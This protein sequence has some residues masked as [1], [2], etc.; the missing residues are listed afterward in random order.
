ML[1][2]WPWIIICPLACSTRCRKAP[3]HRLVRC[4]QFHPTE[5]PLTGGWLLGGGALSKLHQVPG[6][7]RIEDR[8]SFFLV[9]FSK[10]L[11]GGRVERL[12]KYLLLFKLACLTLIVMATQRKDGFLQRTLFRRMGR[13]VGNYVLSARAS[14][15]G[16][17]AT[18]VSLGLVRGLCFISSVCGVICQP[19]F[20]P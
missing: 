16:W 20:L 14:E 2:V 8:L 11:F 17:A 18:W 6:C 12:M 7:I 5:E 19:V 9:P 3:H 13:K 15:M 1:R 10:W 4:G